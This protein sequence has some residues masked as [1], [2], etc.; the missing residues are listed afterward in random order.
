MGIFSRNKKDKKADA[1]EAKPESDVKVEKKAAKKVAEKPEKKPKE[2]KARKFLGK[3][4][5]KAVDSADKKSKDSE[6]KKTGTIEQPG[7]II[8]KPIITEKSSMSGTYQ[9]EVAQDAN[10]IEVAKAF[11]AIY[12]KVPRKV[13]MMNVRGRQVRFG[14]QMGRRASWKKAIGYINQGESIDLY[15]E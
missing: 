10:R 1:P 15:S 8:I 9:F 2:S 7:K 5:D 14:R 12:D 4:K 6:E 11:T 13:N 3:R